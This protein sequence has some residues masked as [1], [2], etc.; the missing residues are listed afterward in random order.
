MTQSEFSSAA[1]EIMND[2]LTEAAAAVEH[3]S[4]DLYKAVKGVAQ[5]EPILSGLLAGAVIGF[6]LGALWRMG[7]RPSFAGYYR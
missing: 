5:D 7:S 3:A 4:A 2:T 1:N 6:A